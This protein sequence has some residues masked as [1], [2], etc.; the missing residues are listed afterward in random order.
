MKGAFGGHVAWQVD[1]VPKGS[2][3]LFC[4]NCCHFFGHDRCSASD[5]SGSFCVLDKKVAEIIF[6]F[7]VF[8]FPRGRN[9]L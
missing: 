5:A 7:S 9:V 1:E 4:E 3:I 2:K 6:T 8:M